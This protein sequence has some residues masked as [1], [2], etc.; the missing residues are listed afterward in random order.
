MAPERPK[1]EALVR[2]GFEAWN[3]DDW[4]RLMGFYEPDAVVKAPEGWP[5]AGD[6]HGREE[7]RRQFERLKEPL[8]DE[9]AE[10]VGIEAEADRALAEVV[11][12][13]TG[14]GS[15]LEMRIPMWIIYVAPGDR[16]SRTEFYL[17]EAKAREAWEAPRPE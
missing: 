15:G 1:I 7:I 6:S 2:D 11:W 17:E 8:R 13:G 10:L 4:D 12:A 9:R 3:A 14:E 5:E 16:F